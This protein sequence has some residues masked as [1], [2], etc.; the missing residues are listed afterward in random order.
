MK[1]EVLGAIIA[2]IFGI[3]WVTIGFGSAVLVGLLA[4]I[5]FLLGKYGRSLLSQLISEVM[6]ALNMDRKQS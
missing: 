5:G 2:M 4:L 6:S 1:S 3:I